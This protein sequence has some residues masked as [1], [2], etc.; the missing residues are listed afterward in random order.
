MAFFN[1]KR[2]DFSIQPPTQ[3]IANGAFTVSDTANIDFTYALNNLTADLTNTGVVAGTYGDATNI[4]VLQIDQWGRV[5]GVTTIPIG[6]GGGTYTVDNGLTESPANNFQLGGTLIQDT[7]IVNSTY[8]TLFTGAVTGSSSGVL[9][10]ANSVNGNAIYGYNSVNGIGVYGRSESGVGIY[11]RSTTGIAGSFLAFNNYGITSEAYNYPFIRGASLYPSNNV[12]ETVLEINR[13]NN[14]ALVGANGVGLDIELKSMTDQSPVTASV[15]TRIRSIWSTA[16]HATR[17]SQFELFVVNNTS[18]LKALTIEGT[19]KIKLDQYLLGAFSGTAA[20]NLQLDSSGYLIATSTGGGGGG[21]TSI[22]GDTTAAQTL[23]NGF[24]GTTPNWSSGGAG[25]RELNIPMSTTP[26]VTAGLVSYDQTIRYENAAYPYV[27]Q[28][29]ISGNLGSAIINVGDL[30]FAAYTTGGQV[31]ATNKNTGTIQSTTPIASA[32]GLVHVKL[33]NEVW[34]FSTAGAV[35]RFNALTGVSLGST[36]VTGLTGGCRGVYDDSLVTGKVYAYFG[37][38]MNIINPLTFVRTSAPL[39]G[40]NTGSH[41][42]TLVTGGLQSG[43]LVGNNRGGIFGFNKAI[44]TQSYFTAPF[45]NNDGYIKYIP[46]INKFVMSYIGNSRL[47]FIEP[48]T[49]TT[50]TFTTTLDG[51]LNPYQFEFDEIENRLFAFNTGAKIYVIELTTLT[52]IKAMPLT[53]STAGSGTFVC[54]DKANKTLYVVG[55]AN[56]GGIAK[57]IYA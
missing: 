28:E 10:A 6:G 38:T 11:G 9:R 44:G 40:V 5:T 49:A 51:I 48:T 14:A 32:T 37:T 25:D 52:W 33:I 7:T 46:S 31:I 45:G 3:S 19:G 1:N 56:G 12:P 20:Y 4:P 13:Y 18:E 54:A 15:A 47:Y 35:S 22:D 21:I 42:L 27:S 2:K 41:E 57:V 8:Y 23:S 30:I 50:L 36:P 24:S 17:V 29:Y 53:I 16:A 55:T 34:C 26:G 39:S 43:L